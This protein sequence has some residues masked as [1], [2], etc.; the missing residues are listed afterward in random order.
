MADDDDDDGVDSDGDDEIT[1][2]YSNT[3]SAAVL[4]AARC[5]L[6]P[7]ESAQCSH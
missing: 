3:C 1:L 6:Q 2:C 5:R 4:G 7:A